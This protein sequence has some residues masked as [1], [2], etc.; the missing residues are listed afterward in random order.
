[1]SVRKVCH[2]HTVPQ[3]PALTS[4]FYLV[5]ESQIRDCTP[6]DQ[7]TPVHEGNL[8]ETIPRPDPN[9]N[10][11]ITRALAPPEGAAD[12]G[13]NSLT[14]SAINEYIIRKT[15][16][17]I[18]TVRGGMQAL[19]NITDRHHHTPTVIVIMAKGTTSGCVRPQEDREPL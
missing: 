19:I 17:L 9:L 14:T 5:F 6:H 3:G 1:M 18:C 13:R 7:A 16:Q 2:V 4:G 8:Q 12:T 11:N 15:K 10:K